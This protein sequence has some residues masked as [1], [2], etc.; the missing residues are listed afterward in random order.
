VANVKWVWSGGVTAHSGVVN[1]RVTAPGAKVRL[2]LARAP[3]PGGPVQR[4]EAV[5]GSNGV[6]KFELDNLVAATQYQYRVESDGPVIGEGRFCTFADGPFS[7]RVAFASCAKTGSDSPVF[8]AIRAAQPDLFVH[9]GDF[10]YENIT[11]ND[12]QRFLQAY[13]AVLTAA[14]QSRLYRSV[15]IAY[16]WD[17]HDFGGNNSNRSAASRP[18]ALGAYRQMVPHY[19]LQ[20]EGVDGIHQGFNI[21][22]VRV[23]LTDAR[24]QRPP[25]RGDPGTRSLLGERQLEWLKSQFSDAASAP[26]VIWVN[27]VPWISKTGSGSD[28]WGAYSGEREEIANH[29]VRVGLA[30][31]LVMLSGDAHMVA[32]DDGAHSNYATGA[33]GKGPGFPVIHAAPLDRRTT[34]KGGPYSH[35]VSRRNG[36]FGLL[37]VTDDGIELRVELSGH[38]MK[39]ALIPGMRLRLVC[40]RTGCRVSDR[41]EETI[42]P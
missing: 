22:R 4:Y 17:D 23:I 15:P 1:S 13:D 38:D 18:A 29:I 25:G 42:A 41:Q 6:V 16:T 35:G 14:S 28:D 19:P 9:M 26:F 10:H 27:S 12:P 24:S 32:I 20:E 5:S 34:E 31:R 36:Q 2:V 11:R 8:D 40:S 30:H 37:Q 21:G 7:F 3:D 39:G 33:A